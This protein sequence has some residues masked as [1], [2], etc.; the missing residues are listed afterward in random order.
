MIINEN[1]NSFPIQEDLHDILAQHP[2]FNVADFRLGKAG[3]P[4]ALYKRLFIRYLSAMPYGT[5]TK[6]RRD[7]DPFVFVTDK[8]VEELYQIN[9]GF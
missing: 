8:L 6:L 2:E 1:T 9:R 7:G 4:N 5:V 3:I